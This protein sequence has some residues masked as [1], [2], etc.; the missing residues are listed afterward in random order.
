MTIEAITEKLNA[1]LKVYHERISFETEACLQ[2]IDVTRLVNELVER[3]GVRNGLANIQ[4]RHTTTAIMI[5]ENEPLLIQDMKK[6]LQA[7]APH[8]AS[9]RHDD[10]EIRK[11][12]MCPDEEKNGHS[13]CKAMFLKT[14]EALNIV[15]GVVQLGQWQRVFFIELDRPRKR[16]ISVVVIGQSD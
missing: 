15:D 1:T 13:H 14:S 2:F 4:T 16:A 7:V 5:N 10:F 8:D 12:N 11:V 6:R 9:Y 3:S